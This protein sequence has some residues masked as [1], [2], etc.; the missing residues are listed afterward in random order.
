MKEVVQKL[1]KFEDGNIQFLRSSMIE[2]VTV[3]NTDG[4]CILEEV[5]P[6]KDFIFQLLVSGIYL[7]VV[8]LRGGGY[9]TRIINNRKLI[10]DCA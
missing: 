8:N 1:V 6:L 5:D 10:G 3:Y 9:F 7:V 2:Y 4:T